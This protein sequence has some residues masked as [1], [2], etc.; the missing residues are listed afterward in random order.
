MHPVGDYA[1]R[2]IVLIPREA[3]C[4]TPLLSMIMP[5]LAI[6]HLKTPAAN[7]LVILSRFREVAAL[8]QKIW[9]L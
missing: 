5:S 2:K 3:T 4:S 7:V 6:V 9:M 8:I 1:H